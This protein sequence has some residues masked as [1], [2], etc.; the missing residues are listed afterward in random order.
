MEYTMYTHSDSESERTMPGNRGNR[1][2]R[3]KK[4]SSGMKDVRAYGKNS[5][6][7]FGTGKNNSTSGG[8]WVSPY[9]IGSGKKRKK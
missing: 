9:D 1:D 3:T 5:K 7:S 6:S 2:S 8:S 4:Q